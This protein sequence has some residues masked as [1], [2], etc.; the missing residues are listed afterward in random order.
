VQ[1]SPL[2]SAAD[3]LFSEPGLFSKPGNSSSSSSTQLGFAGRVQERLL[4]MSGSVMGFLWGHSDTRNLL[5][6]FDR[7]STAAAPAAA[8]EAA[9]GSQQQRHQ[10][11][12]LSETSV[13]DALK[14]HQ[15]NQ[16]QQQQHS[17][18]LAAAA[19]DL[20][21]DPELDPRAL[22]ADMALLD[23]AGVVLGLH[24]AQLF[25]ALYM[26]AHKALVEVRPYQF[27]GVSA[28]C[29]SSSSSSSGSGECWGECWL[30]WSVPAAVAA[31]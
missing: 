20:P 4:E 14:S 13:D 11:R 19:A 22:L 17:R 9:A 7:H 28:G 3:Q 5:N 30:R 26:P 21:S 23:E 12:S 2:P 24:G 8:D 15:H 6:E 29:S 1:K 25:N 18:H 16:Q 31:S 10:Q 27:T